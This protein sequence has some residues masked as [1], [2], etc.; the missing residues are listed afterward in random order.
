MFIRSQDKRVLVKTD[1]VYIHNFL[2]IKCLKGE[3]FI[4]LGTYETR[5]RALEVLDMIENRIIK[6]STFDF[7]NKCKRTTKEFVFKMPEE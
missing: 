3:E 1:I 5:E 4:H 6:G 7:I 2:Q